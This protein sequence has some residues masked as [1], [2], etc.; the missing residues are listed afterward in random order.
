MA[1]KKYK[2]KR[3]PF[4]RELKSTWPLY[5]MFALPAIWF[6]VFSYVPMAGLLMA[7]NEYEPGS[8]ILGFFTS[9]WVGLQHFTRFFTSFYAWR[10][11]RNTVVISLL[12]IAVNFFSPILLAL[13]FNELINKTFKKIAQSI[14]YLPKFISMVVIV[15]ILRQLLGYTDGMINNIIEA[16]GGERIY[17]LSEPKYFWTIFTLMNTWATIGWSSIV[18]VS[19]ISTL[20]PDLYEACKIDGGGR[21]RMIWN[22]TLPGIRN[23]IMTM[24]ILRMGTVLTVGLEP[25]LLLSSPVLYETAEVFSLHVYNYGLRDMDYSY[26]AAVGLLQS[27]F[28]LIMVLITN[29]ISRKVA[30]YGLW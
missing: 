24:F 5:A 29:A 21:F 17:F 26:A 22:I 28:G 12:D 9:D 23:T 15:S 6:V 14:T 7:F 18:Y 2:I 13:M 20:P 11:I 30:N 16:F 27:V 19:A 4:L 3:T 25:I 1:A 8:G 10:V